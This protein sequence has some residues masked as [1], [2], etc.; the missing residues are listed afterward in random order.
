MIWLYSELDSCSQRVN[1]HTRDKTVS[2]END[3]FLLFFYRDYLHSG[4]SSLWF[5]PFPPRASASPTAPSSHCTWGNVFFHSIISGNCTSSSFGFPSPCSLLIHARSKCASSVIP[6]LSSGTTFLSGTSQHICA[7]LW[8]LLFEHWG[9]LC[10]LSCTL[11]RRCCLPLLL[12]LWRMWPAASPVWSATPRPS[13]GFAILVSNTFTLGH[14]RTAA[15]PLP[16]NAFPPT[17][18]DLSSPGN[19]TSFL[20]PGFLW[21]FPDLSMSQSPPLTPS[22]LSVTLFLVWESWNMT[23]AVPEEWYLSPSVCIWGT[24]ELA[25][26]LHFFSS[27]TPYYPPKSP[28]VWFVTSK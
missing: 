12:C 11:Q 25:S 14:Y 21:P 7:Y 8:L 1:D 13:P 3:S 15:L 17:A 6:P 19:C 23:Q 24:M 2:F 16:Q 26:K 20:K 28:Q 27:N 9:H 10:L 4:S 18:P 5:P 22:N